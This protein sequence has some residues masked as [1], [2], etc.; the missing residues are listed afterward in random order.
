MFSQILTGY[1]SLP[2]KNY[3]SRF[4]KKTFKKIEKKNSIGTI[5]FGY[6]NKQKYSTYVSKKCWEDKYVDL[7]LIG[8][9]K[10]HYTLIKNFNT[11]MYDHTLDCG[12]KH[13]C[14]NCLQTFRTA[15]NFKCHVKD[16]LGK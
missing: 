13:F 1:R 11:F 7:L 15:E 14:W 10:R 16:Y 2:S 8:E 9:D 4:F 12:R 3:K 5:V 6:E